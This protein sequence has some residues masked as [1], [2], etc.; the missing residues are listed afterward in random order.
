MRVK[1]AQSGTPWRSNHERSRQE[2]CLRGVAFAAEGGAWRAQSHDGCRHANRHVGY[3][4][5]GQ[6]L[7]Q[8][9][10]SARLFSLVAVSV[11]RTAGI[12]QFVPRTT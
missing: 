7:S 1:Q 5:C 4:Q 12:Q 10:H 11:S 8:A 3:R 9:S 2:R 6:R